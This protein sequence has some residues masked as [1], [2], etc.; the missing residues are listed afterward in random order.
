MKRIFLFLCCAA[1]L[2]WSGCTKDN[3][4]NT[5]D[6][7]QLVGTWE[8]TKMYIGEYGE[9]DEEYGS[10]FNFVSTKEFHA[11]GTVT[12]AETQSGYTRSWNLIYTI[13]SNIL[14]ISETDT[15]HAISVRIEKLTASE[16][17]TSY[18]YKGENGKTYV[19]KVYHKRID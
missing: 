14:T 17:I 6:L 16:F 11:D 4:D 1:A 9:W 13:D 12:V 18:E 19:D 7:T 10:E 5:V 15:D 2:S 8:I 3:D